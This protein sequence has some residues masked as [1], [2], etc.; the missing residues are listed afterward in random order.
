MKLQVDGDDYDSFE[1]LSATINLD[2]LSNSFSFTTTSQD[3]K[4][5][6]FVGGEACRVLVDGE[7]QVTGV[8]EIVREN[9]SADDHGI[10]YGGRDNTA[11]IVDS[12]V[13][14]ISDIRAPI[15][16]KSL[17]EKTISHIG[18]DVKVV[19][20]V[21]PDEFN[22]A[23]DVSA[24]EPGDNAFQFLE[25]WSRKRH[26]LLTS[27][28]DA[29][30]VISPSKGR[31]IS[32][33]LRHQIGSDANNILSHSVSYN[34][35]GL[36][37][38]YQFASQLNPIATVR[39]GDTD[40]ES[41]VDQSGGVVQSDAGV[42]D[43]RTLTLV[44]ESSASATQNTDR[45]TWEA[46]VR[47]SRSRVYSCTVHGYRNTTGDLWRTNTIVQVVDDYARIDSPMLINNVEF[48]LDQRGGSSTTLTLVDQNAYELE[49]SEPKT[50][51]LGDGLI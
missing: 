50:Q 12:T 32:A 46:R 48:N 37:S 28:G 35:T 19:D 39:S 47:K 1:S 16:L 27:N 20:Q 33:T 45:A 5:M 11:D 29:D 36:Y 31:K 49:L 9:T 21:S 13:G 3:G 17:C 15:T 22:E 51:D 2:A 34:L 8:I 23:E 18:S 44:S 42:R 24:P 43:G 25:I 7:I 6:P 4:A 10:Q 41:L 14:L 40:L 38:R 26:V 30:L